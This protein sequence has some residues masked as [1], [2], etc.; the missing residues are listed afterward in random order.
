[1][2][3]INRVKNLLSVC[4][5]LVVLLAGCNSD[6]KKDK[7]E[8]SDQ[9]NAQ[10]TTEAQS[11]KGTL[12]ALLNV[13][14]EEF[15][16]KASDHTKEV[17]SSGIKAVTNSGILDA[18]LQVGD[19]APDFTLP[20]AL[21]EEV[22]L[23]S[24]LEKGPVVLTWYRGGWCPYCNITLQYLQQRL[25]DFKKEGASLLALTPELPDKSLD[26][27]EK[28]DLQF[29]VLSDVGNKVGKEYGVV[30]QLT[31]EVAGIY[32]ESFDLHGYNGDGSNELPLAATYVIDSEGVIQYA[33]LD[34]DY[35]NRA[36]P[37]EIV[38]Q[39]KKLH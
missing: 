33:F 25:P 9:Q 6:N 21:G 26:T 12:D 27:K 24:Q 22:T 5:I 16:K 3:H 36:E 11:E 17:Y 37:D 7:M 35:R 14:R 23:Y 4:V 34:A 1:M 10:E 19:K 30:F 13:R 2:N 32:Q 31:D 18:A 8:Q 39:L 28:H 38:A 29:Q 15:A 20:D